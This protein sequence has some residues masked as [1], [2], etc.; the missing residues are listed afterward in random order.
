M[1]TEKLQRIIKREI[2]SL[3]ECGMVDFDRPTLAIEEMY[4]G[5]IWF[6]GELSKRR[7]YRSGGCETTTFEVKGVI[8]LVN[9]NTEKEK[10]IDFDG[11]EIESEYVYDEYEYNGVSRYDF[12]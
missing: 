12:Y 11:M 6:D 7:S 8:T 9:R 3:A 4:N 1:N 5:T 2:E 10:T